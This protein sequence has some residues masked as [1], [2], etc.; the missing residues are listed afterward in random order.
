M[1]KRKFIYMF[2]I[3]L[4]ISVVIPIQPAYGSTV[5]AEIKSSD[6]GEDTHNDA[7][8][9]LRTLFMS[10]F[11]ILGESSI[12]TEQ[13]WTDFINTVNESAIV[14]TNNELYTHNQIDVYYEKLLAAI[15]QLEEKTIINHITDEDLIQL[16][17]ESRTNV[18]E[19]D[20]L[21]ENWTI[22]QR[23]L[24]EAQLFY[25]L[26]NRNEV[27]GNIQEQ[28]DQIYNDLLSSKLNTGL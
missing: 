18:N 25:R 15:N 19:R 27:T 14:L 28:L 8:E 22:F 13:S 16:I 4:L 3:T 17:F 1:K 26:L 21:P 5:N 12:Y 11:Y 6:I 2:L 10:I 9:R 20:F 7:V 23:K 24:T